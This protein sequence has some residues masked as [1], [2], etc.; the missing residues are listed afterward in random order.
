MV[1]MDYPGPCMSCDAISGCASE[2]TRKAAVQTYCKGIERELDAWKAALYDVMAKFVAMDG[3]DQA[4]IKDSI[5]EI[6]SIVATI[7]D[8]AKQL[9]A[10]CPLDVSPAEKEIGDKLNQ[11]RVH[12]TKAMS[13]LGAG[14]FGG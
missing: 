10:E 9:E 6:K 12:Y 1:N 14:N 5:M 8:K 3:K 2:A 13:V 4:A 11:L 7:E